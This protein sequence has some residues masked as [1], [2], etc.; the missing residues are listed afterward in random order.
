M[1]QKLKELDPLKQTTH[2]EGRQEEIILYM[3]IKKNQ[4]KNRC[5]EVGQY[6]ERS[7]TVS[8]VV[9]VLVA[10][11]VSVLV[12][13]V[14]AVLV[15]RA[16]HTQRLLDGHFLPPQLHGVHQVVDDGHGPHGRRVP[17][18]DVAVLAHQQH[19]EVF[20][21]DL[22]V[23]PHVLDQCGR[24]AFALHCSAACTQRRDSA[25]DSKLT[26]SL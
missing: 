20:G 5:N 3:Y 8:L 16:A 26:G 23:I 1:L 10:V 17:G 24:Q 21:A 15:L 22:E 18:L 14:A 12:V 19:G 4:I 11:F 6:R 2:K 13:A 9:V 25:F 7:V